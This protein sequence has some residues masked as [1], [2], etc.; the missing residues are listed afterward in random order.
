MRYTLAMGKTFLYSAAWLLCAVALPATAQPSYPAKTVRVIVPYP[1]GGGND[2]IGRAVAE[3]LTRRLG[4][5]FIIDNRPGGSTVIG[6][7]IA[8]R[9]PPDGYHLLVSSQTTFAIVPH[10]K[11]KVPYDPVNDFAP[12]SLL[13]TQ[14]Y[15]VVVHPSLPART[16]KEL[17]AVAKAQPGKI[18][19]ASASV[20]SGSHLQ[21]EMFKAQTGTNMMHIPYKGS[22]PAIADLLGGQVSLMFSTASSVHPFVL[23]G[24]LRAIAITSTQRHPTLP[25]V[26]T[27]AETM[28]GFEN[29]AWNAMVAPR[30]TPKE[31]IE[32]LNA[33]IATIAK[34]QDFRNRMAAQ[35]YDAESSTPQQLTAR[36]QSELAR[37]GK[38]INA[39]GLKDEQ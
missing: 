23:A 11:T 9:A 4:Q 34:A 21:G 13:A 30:A 10:V 26:P 35:G 6:A 38:L 18:L 12:V 22:G 2:I 20:G 31:V 33:A 25:N 17:I 32:R 27:V 16:V 1:P 24:R 7:E 29:T 8:M 36:M 28:K 14:P 15:L 37:F 3:E 39:I 19:Y 5:T